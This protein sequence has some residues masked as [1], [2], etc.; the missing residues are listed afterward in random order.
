[1][2]GRACC[3]TKKEDVANCTSRPCDSDCDGGDLSIVSNCCEN[4]ASIPC[5]DGKLCIDGAVFG[6]TKLMLFIYIT[7][8][9]GYS[10]L[11]YFYSCLCFYI[12]ECATDND[13]N[14]GFLCRSG[15]CSKLLS[16]PIFQLS[17]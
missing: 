2:H 3:K 11:V 6:G 15:S 9:F 4:D 8:E 17:D 14:K 13:C 16:F 1:M 10:I 7:E 12:T 5:P